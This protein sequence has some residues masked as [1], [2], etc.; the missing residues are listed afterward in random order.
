METLIF[1]GFIAL[2]MW[3]KN[4]S[5]RLSA[6]EQRGEKKVVPPL[7]M[8][9]PGTFTPPSEVPHAVIPASEIS[10][11]VPPAPAPHVEPTTSVA[12]SV[13]TPV[14]VPPPPSVSKPNPFFEWFS[15]NTLIK[16]GAFLFFLGAVWFVSYA[17][18]Q[19]WIS[20]LMRIVMG[21]TL[22][23]AVC[24]LGAWRKYANV[25]HY[26]VLTTLGVGIITASIFTGQF[27]FKL[28]PPAFALVLLLGTIGY[29][30]LVSLQTRTEWLCVLSATTT[31]LAP[32]LVNIPDLNHVLFLVYLLGVSLGFLAVVFMTHWRGVTLTLAVGTA[33]FVWNIC[34]DSAAIAPDIAWLFVLLFTG[35]FYTAS[36]VSMFRNSSVESADVTTLGISVVTFVTMA[37]ALT[38]AEGLITFVA[39]FIAAGTGYVLY[40]AQRSEKI[41]SV[42]AGLATLLICIA[43]AFTFDGYTLTMVYT[44]EI[45]TVLI[46]G[47]H[48]GLSQNVILATTWLFTLPVVLSF[49]EFQAPEWGM[50]SVWHGS[51]VSI[52]TLTLATAL[53]A[54]YAIIQSKRTQ[55]LLYQS[56]GGVFT[57]LFWVYACATAASVWSALFSG[58]LAYALQYITWSIVCVLV[59]IFV[60]RRG[61]PASWM[62]LAL[63]AFML[64]VF[65]SLGASV[66]P[67]WATEWIHPNGVGLYFM[68]ALSL[69]MGLWFVL[70]GMLRQNASLRMI[71]GI[72]LGIFWLY[73]LVTSFLFWS[74]IC[75]DQGIAH[76]LSY[77]SW[78]VVS[79]FFINAALHPALSS[80]WLAGAFA[81]LVVPVVASLTSFGVS[82]WAYSA[83][84]PDAVGLYTLTTVLVLLVL[85]FMR[86]K[87]GYQGDH[88]LLHAC[89]TILWSVIGIYGVSLI[90]LITH[91]VF[92]A[93][94]VAV[95]VA[96]FIYTVSGLAMYSVGKSMQND[97][98]RYVGI[99]LLSGVVLRLLIV[100]VWKMEI[101]GRIVTFLGV[102]LLFILTAL[103]EKPFEN[104]G[105]GDGV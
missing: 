99:I 54:V 51:A 98:I 58:S 74:A 21:V 60:V 32:L 104:V 66:D 67:R 13:E 1:F 33:L 7:T 10:H 29:A 86:I 85:A 95:S 64:P 94:D 5:D 83:I 72:W 70:W 2:F 71:G 14:P 79:Y 44:L 49:H 43:T 11:D 62:H 93:E 30:V 73:M 47:L 53:C 16:I 24:A 75:V 25:E 105:K 100:D 31:L 88:G 45:T 90:W 101:L 69:L 28:F 91:A 63:F 92:G 18:A 50:G 4:L 57:T 84:H 96:L 40:A 48:L 15:E 55:N 8:Y 52:Y 35:I 6:L 22:G 77:I 3:C 12:A 19:G 102:G 42:Y 97:I 46:L 89:I 20:P 68:T 39:A 61:M 23:V 76:V 82:A 37:Y 103:F 87:Q 80:R 56:I 65:A 41:V 17:I 38:N 26:L 34:L 36:A 9:A 78:A 27:L 81:T 59:L